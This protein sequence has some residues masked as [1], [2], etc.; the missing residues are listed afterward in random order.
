MSIKNIRTT[1]I[2]SFIIFSVLII[3]CNLI[4]KN[5][6]D[7]IGIEWQQFDTGPSQ[8]SAL[9]ND[10]R[11]AMGLGGVVHEFQNYI[12]Q[13]DRVLLVNIAR[14]LRN[15]TV[16]LTAY[17][18]LSNNP[19]E[20]M[21]IADISATLFQYQENMAKV[22]ILLG[23][24]TDIP[25]IYSLVN[26]D[27]EKALQGLTAL[28]NEI[29]ILRTESTS[30]IY[31]TVDIVDTTV[32][33][34]SIAIL[35]LIISLASFISITL[36]RL[37]QRLG[38]EPSRIIQIVKRIADGD[39]SE[40]LN[41]ESVKRCGIFKAMQQ[42]QLNLKQQIEDERKS[43]EENNRLRQALDSA[44][45]P[46]LVVD[47]DYR[48]IYANDTAGKLF[49]EVEPDVKE[50][51]EHF[52]ALQIVGI[53]V[54]DIKTIQGEHLDS[55]AVKNSGHAHD[56][57]FGKHTFSVRV[58]P[59]ISHDRS[60]V[61][62]V[63]E[64]TDNTKALKLQNEIAQVVKAA[65]AGDLS[66]RINTSDNDNLFCAF[67]D[68]MN[69]LI[70]VNESVINE[71]LRIL[72]SMA[73]GNLNVE[74]TTAYGGAF[75]QLKDNF[76]STLTKLSQLI[77]ELKG[78]VSALS[79]SSEH[80]VHIGDNL[81]KA[82]ASSS[83]QAAEASESAQSV[84]ESIESVAAATVQMTA[85]IK[86]IVGNIN[87]SVGVAREAASIA[88]NADSNVRKL[89]DSSAA[90]GGVTKVITSIAEQ[91]NLLALNATIEAAR[92]GESG[93]GFAVVANEVKELAKETAKATEQI[94]GTIHTI[95]S[96]TDI[97]VKAIGEIAIIVQRINEYQDAVMVA[98]E[99]QSAATNE[100]N[101]SIQD[102]AS[103]STQ[104]AHSIEHVAKD[105]GTVQSN[106]DQASMASRELEALSGTLNDIAQRFQ[107]ND[108]YS[109]NSRMTISKHCE[110][111]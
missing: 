25:E 6:V 83:E 73:N 71:V 80:V 28:D 30:H 88:Q 110:T 31:E 95:Q 68:G 75:E 98:M 9:L 1:L 67:G 41:S 26:I 54:G 90:I 63:L 16:A 7:G 58:S 102:A 36:H 45:S 86:G 107:I 101:R 39:L 87:E 19:V 92:A 29:D 53:N 43:A 34:S 77:S 12:F 40:N 42:M 3:A 59:I 97:A 89:C 27:N 32:I 18:S 5:K 111:G 21:A 74:M 99:E 69:N 106:A 66:Q 109:T 105:S 52:N 51:I 65:T 64:W 91:T 104:I 96:D 17:S 8:K 103:S 72:E 82:V 62:S 84:S 79:Q 93:K 22:E 46:V 4:I 33:S 76:N 60:N 35:F 11:G 49:F 23:E 15:A 38:G 2:V 24:N 13:H 56:V 85:S 78:G 47:A 14:E 100:I 37:L 94:D 70:D 61:G 44:S 50:Q 48:V 57:A 20:E 55:I 10:I 81:G 108:R